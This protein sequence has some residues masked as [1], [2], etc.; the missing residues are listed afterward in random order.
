MKK[1]IVAVG[2]LLTVAACSSSPA[3]TTRTSPTPTPAPGNNAT[4]G[5]DPVSVVRAFLAAAKTQDLQA[6]SLYFGNQDGPARDV[7]DRQELEQR[8]IVMATCLQYDRYDIVGD[9][10]GMAGARVLAVSLTKNGRS[11][12]AN[13]ETIASN[14]D[15]RWYVKSFDLGKLMQDY[16]ARH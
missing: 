5:A 14:R 3:P 10:P 13:F 9:A 11:A 4:G 6:M 16:C 15:H 2:I 8:E 7:I 1:L 12:S